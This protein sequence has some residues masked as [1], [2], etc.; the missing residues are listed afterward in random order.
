MG[1][2]H[3]NAS[4]LSV[5][6]DADAGISLVTGFSLGGS[7]SLSVASPLL[8][9]FDTLV[10]GVNFLVPSSILSGFTELISEYI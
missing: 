8:V 3:G 10:G 1:Y 4:G 5:T 6:G 7:T 2:G 9:A